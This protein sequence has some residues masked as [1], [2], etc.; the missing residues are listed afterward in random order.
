MAAKDKAKYEKAAEKPM[1][2]YRKDF[3]K[4][5]ESGQAEFWKRDPNKPKKPLCAQLAYRVDAKIAASELKKAWAAL[6]APKKA[7]YQKQ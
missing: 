2:A 4:Y 1:E 3:K 6:A 5:Q 7:T